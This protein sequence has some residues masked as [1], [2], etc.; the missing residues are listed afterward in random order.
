MR[1]WNKWN[2]EELALKVKYAKGSNKRAKCLV[3]VKAKS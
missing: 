1:V 2:E 3:Q